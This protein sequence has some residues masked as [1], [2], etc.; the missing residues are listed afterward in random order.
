MHSSWHLPN[1][2]IR[3]PLQSLLIE[4]P[5]ATLDG[6][7]V[8]LQLAAVKTAPIAKGRARIHAERAPAVRVQRCFVF[9]VTTPPCDSKFASKEHGAGRIARRASPLVR[10]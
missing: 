5:A 6:A 1:A 2:Q 4:Q 8:L 9:I 3:F 7:G 10:P